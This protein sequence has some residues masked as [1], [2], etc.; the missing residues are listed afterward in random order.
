MYNWSSFPGPG[1]ADSKFMGRSPVQKVTFV[2]IQF[3][4]R[5]LGASEGCRGEFRSPL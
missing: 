1:L 5:L 3:W 4:K 2:G